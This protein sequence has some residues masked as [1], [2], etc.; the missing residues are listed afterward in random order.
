MNVAPSLPLAIRGHA[1]ARPQALAVRDAAGDLTYGELDR[2]ADTVA[3]ALEERGIARGDRVALLAVPS[4]EAIALLAG[5]ARAGAVAV[6]LGTRLTRREVAGVLGEATPVLLVHDADLA[7][8]AIGH[9]V[10]AIAISALLADAPPHAPAA[11]SGAL[12]PV[13]PPRD[14]DVDTD[15][16][17]VAVFT[18]GTAGPPRAALLSDR[19]LAASAAAWTAALPP[20]TGWLL[21]LGLAH[22]AG[23]G[24]VWRALGAGLP[25]QVVSGFEPD[26]VLALLRGPD[27]PSHVSLV[28]VQLARLLKVAADA[29]APAALRAVLLGGAPIPPDLVRR[30]IACRLAGGPD[31]WPDRGRLG[32]DGTS[33]R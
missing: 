15:A 33:D 18:S 17:V 16:P 21:V 25:L 8:V 2:A 29:P 5:I 32:R 3:A 24:V 12:P 27:A 11:A 1:A 13:T 7:P 31:L 28:P 20:A 30:A 14:L 4:R 9:A 26:V 19:A 10:P 6:P 22:V 23:L